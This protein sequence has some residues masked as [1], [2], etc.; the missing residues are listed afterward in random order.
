MKLIKVASNNCMGNRYFFEKFLIFLA[1]MS[2]DK[3]E[4]S[5][6]FIQMRFAQKI[7]SKITYNIY[8]A[9]FLVP[10]YHCIVSIFKTFIHKMHK[11][12]FFKRYTTNGNLKSYMYLNE[13]SIF[14]S[15]T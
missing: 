9:Q 11:L 7:N 10:L 13:C 8:S 6:D 12:S 3:E 14:P 2:M 15:P 4:Q 1:V 5:A